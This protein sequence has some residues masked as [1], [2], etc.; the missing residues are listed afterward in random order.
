MDSLNIF[1]Q[2]DFWWYGI[3]VILQDPSVMYILSHIWNRCAVYFIRYLSLPAG[4]W[5]LLLSNIW[6]PC[7]WSGRRALCGVL[8]VGF[9]SLPS[10]IPSSFRSLILVVNLPSH[11]KP[12]RGHKSGQDH[13][14]ISVSLHKSNSFTILQHHT[15]KYAC[16]A[17]S[18]PAAL[19]DCLPEEWKPLGIV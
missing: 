16:L 6:V 8:F 15:L 19:L 4:Q 9:F 13:P 11:L 14:K 18:L 17:R 12:A 1:H 3:E 7:C 2:R 10:K 5:G